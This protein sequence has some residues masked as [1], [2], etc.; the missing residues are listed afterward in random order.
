MRFVW[1][2]R[3]PGLHFC[4]MS[5]NIGEL[6]VPKMGALV[7]GKH[8]AFM[9]TKNAYYNIVWHKKG[10]RAASNVESDKPLS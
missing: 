2:L 3:V 8:W 5:F 9:A 7:M 4:S 6:E 1:N 10:R